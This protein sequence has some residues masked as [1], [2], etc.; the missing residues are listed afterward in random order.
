MCAKGS[1]IL[2][3]SLIAACA[4][5]AGDEEQ[6]V[7]VARFF[8]REYLQ[9]TDAYRIFAA[10]CRICQA[11]VSWYSS[12][13]AQKF[14]LRQIRHMD[15]ATTATSTSRSAGSGGDGGGDGGA[16]LDVCLLTIYGHIMFTTTS[17]TYALSESLS[18]PV[19]PSVGFFQSF[20]S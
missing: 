17:Y 5:I 12:G 7:W 9:C 6:C 16:D 2:T 11:P 10:L 19:S 18:R 15:K 20:K 4:I 1:E 13:P 3:P 14:I 8:M